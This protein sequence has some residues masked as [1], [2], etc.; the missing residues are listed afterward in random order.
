MY[1]GC[2]VKAIVPFFFFPSHSIALYKTLFFSPF[3]GVRLELLWWKPLGHPPL[4]LPSSPGRHKLRLSLPSPFPARDESHQAC[5][6]PGPASSPDHFSGPSLSQSREKER[7]DKSAAPP[8]PTLHGCF[9]NCHG[10]QQKNTSG[11]HLCRGK[12][13]A[14]VDHSLLVQPCPTGQAQQIFHQPQY[15]IHSSRR[16]S[17]CICLEIHLWWRQRVDKFS[18]KRHHLLSPTFCELLPFL[19]RKETCV[20]LYREWQGLER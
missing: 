6:V 1:L 3:S 19:W 18:H 11:W 16:Q 10:C 20:N 15:Q 14:L 2:C 7:S 5:L 12:R 13:E 9:L 4:S 17:E 8:A